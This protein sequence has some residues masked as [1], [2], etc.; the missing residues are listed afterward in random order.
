MK[1]QTLRLCDLA[2][3]RETYSKFSLSELQCGQDARTTVILS[4]C[5]ALLFYLYYSEKKRE[6]IYFP[7]SNFQ[8]AK[9]RFC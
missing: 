4:L 7:A 2:A 9:F 3:L 1:S 5:K 6:E 8:L